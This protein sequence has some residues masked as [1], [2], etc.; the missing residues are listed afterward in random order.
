MSEIMAYCGLMCS[1]CPAYKAT[2]ADDTSMREKTAEMW[3]RNYGSDIKPGDINCLGCDSEVLFGHCNVCE[4]R[5]CAKD[6]A[7]ENCGKCESFACGKVEG[8]LN[9]DEGARERL[10]GAKK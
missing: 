5:A 1:E 2:V 4:I 10:T 9:Y 8:V 3:S 6:K 7:L